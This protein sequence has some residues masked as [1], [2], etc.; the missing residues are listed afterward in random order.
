MHK[1]ASKSI[2]RKQMLIRLLI[3]YGLNYEPKALEKTIGDIY[4]YI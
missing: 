1:E 2:R 4:I 3:N